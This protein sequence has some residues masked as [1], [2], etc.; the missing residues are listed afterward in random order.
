[1]FIE[2]KYVELL[3]PQLR[4]FKKTDKTVYNFSCPICGDSERNKRKARGY[5]YVKGEHYIFLHL[6]YSG[7]IFALSN[8][9]SFLSFT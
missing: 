4:N 2:S 9:I 6:I 7:S 1:M 5:V 8:L 3:S